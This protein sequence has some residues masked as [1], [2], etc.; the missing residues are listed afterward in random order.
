MPEKTDPP[1]S[2]VTCRYCGVATP[3]GS[4]QCVEC[5]AEGPLSRSEIRSAPR[6]LRFRVRF[7]GFVRVAIV[8]GIVVGLG[9]AMVS[10]LLAGPPNTSGDPLTTSAGYMVGPGNY[11]VIS[12][13]ITGG[14]YV[15]GNYSSF[16]PVGMNVGF[17]VYNSTQF[18]AFLGGTNPTPS[19]SVPNAFSGRIVY[20]AP[21][22]DNFYFVFSNPYPE[23]SHLTMGIYVATEYESNVGDDGFA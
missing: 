11:T 22:T 6:R 3:S 2:W 16:D 8:V 15:V 12:G 9:Y 23:S 5:G 17:A 13:E 21:V 20:S 10:A 19:Y 18:T 1:G 7:L 4:G 14:D